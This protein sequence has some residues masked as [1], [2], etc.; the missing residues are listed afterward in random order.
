MKDFCKK[1][2]NRPYIWKVQAAMKLSARLPN[3]GPPTPLRVYQHLC[4]RVRPQ[5][6]R[7]TR[8][9]ETQ[10]TSGH[11]LTGYVPIPGRGLPSFI[12]RPPGHFSEAMKSRLCRIKNWPEKAREANYRVDTLAKNCRCSVSQLERFF[13][14]EMKLSP[15]VWM[16]RLRNLQ[17]RAE[18]DEGIPIKET[19][20][21]AGYANASHFSREFK[22]VLGVSPAVAAYRSTPADG[23]KP[24]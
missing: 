22:K 23:V 15:H 14:Q 19:A 9:T 2:K 12:A 1:P 13:E 4:Q 10:E 3:R 17:A 5:Y 20:S 16:T 21:R 8:I 18:L 6:Q 24:A 7:R 11:V